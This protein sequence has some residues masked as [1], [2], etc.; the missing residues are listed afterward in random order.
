MAATAAAAA[1]A[2]TSRT[3][4]IYTSAHPPMPSAPSVKMQSLFEHG[5]IALHGLPCYFRSPI[6]VATCQ[7]VMHKYR[8]SLTHTK[9][10]K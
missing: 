8:N 10:F 4:R 1:A 6:I 3:E 2:A 5:Y 9:N 7:L